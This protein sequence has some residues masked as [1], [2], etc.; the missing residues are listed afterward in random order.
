MPDPTKPNHV[1][2]NKSSPADQWGMQVNRTVQSE[3]T[4]QRGSVFSHTCESWGSEAGWGGKAAELRKSYTA[5]A[6]SNE[7]L[8]PSSS[9]LKQLEGDT[10]RLCQCITQT[11]TGLISLSFSWRTNRTLGPV[12]TPPWD[13]VHGGPRDSVSPGPAYKPFPLAQ[14]QSVTVLKARYILEKHGI[15]GI[16]LTGG[17]G[18][19]RF[20]KYL[21]GPHLGFVLHPV[22]ARNTSRNLSEAYKYLQ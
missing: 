18:K 2:R 14:V 13:Q 19:K 6:M 8:C 11:P 10:P 5:L 1:R 3:L 15:N 7:A 17:A 16:S 21:A 22:L 20:Q 12:H 4:A 9:S